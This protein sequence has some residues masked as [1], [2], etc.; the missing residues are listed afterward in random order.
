MTNNIPSHFDE[1]FLHW[2]REQTEET[3]QSYRTF[4]F[5][6]F[7][8]SRVGGSDWQQGT[9]WLNGLNEQEIT[10]I[11]QRYH[12]RF[13]PDYRLFLKTLHSV[14]R[15]QVGAKYKGGHE[16][17]PI[18]KPSFYNWQ[19]D[20]EAI[21]DAYEWLVS[22]L[23]FD[24]QH[25]DLWPQS[26][27]TKPATAEAQETRVRELVDAAPKLVPVF[28]HRYLLAEPCEA[29][30]PILSIWQSDIIIYDTNLYDYFLDE[31]GALCG[32]SNEDRQRLKAASNQEIQ[33]RF[34]AYRAIPFWGEF[35]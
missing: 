25:N 4:S 9:C 13:P 10:A 7:V 12:L 18:T 31:F 34:E 23:F 11:E 1:T 17:F 24:V 22:G 33:K 2:F 3:W 21:Q 35:L 30:N 20:T 6:E 29:G 19:T 15:L 16:M 5:E 32:V 26:W 8:A 14:D 27:G 28:A